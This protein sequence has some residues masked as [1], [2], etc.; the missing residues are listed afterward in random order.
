MDHLAQPDIADVAQQKQGP[1]DL[2]KL[3]KCEIQLVFAAVG[4][5]PAQ[6][7]RRR[8]LAGLDGHRHPKHCRQMQFNQPPVDHVTEQ[9]IDVLV[10]IARL[11]AMEFEVLD[12]PDARHELD[13]EQVGQ[14]EDRVTLGL[15]VPVNRVRPDVR[16]IGHQP[17]EDV[18]ALIG[19]A[20]N[21]MAEQRDELVRH[22]VVADAAV[23]A[24]T[25]MVLGQEVLLI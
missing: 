20:G 7:G 16:F 14:R 23:A 11:R 25:N 8:D 21:E 24:I 6:D 15:G 13:A 9:R 4:A 2:A 12:A 19:T 5:Q 18:D 22:M 10:S 17:V 3:H 1:D